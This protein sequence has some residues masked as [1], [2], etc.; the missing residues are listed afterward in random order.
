MSS[1]KIKAVNKKTGELHDVWCLDDYFGKHRYGYI[2]NSGEGEGM[3]EDDF[4]RE[5]TPLETRQGDE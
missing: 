3:T 2:P 4:Y 5:Y 1:F